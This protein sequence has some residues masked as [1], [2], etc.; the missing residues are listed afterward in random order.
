MQ[1]DQINDELTKSDI[2]RFW[3]KVNVKSEEECWIWV[4]SIRN[5]G[6]GRMWLN[7]RNPS[8]HRISWVIYNGHIKSGLSVLH[9]CNNKLCVN[10][11]HLYLGTQTDNNADMY[12]C[13]NPPKS[14][15]VSMFS[16]TDIANIK[17]LRSK[18]MTQQNIA[19][20]YKCSRTHITHIV[21]NNKA[22][23]GVNLKPCN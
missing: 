2:D 10:P 16:I 17:E 4:A 15:R 6:Y 5:S 21:N 13:S 11:K 7:G 8:A 23:L 9:R 22:F 19:N 1:P 14:G 20:L 3:A 18:G 12:K